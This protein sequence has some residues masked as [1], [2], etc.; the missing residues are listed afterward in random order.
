MPLNRQPVNRQ[1]SDFSYQIKRTEFF[2]DTVQFNAIEIDNTTSEEY[3]ILSN[4]NV[5]AVRFENVS[6]PG[7]SFPNVSFETYSEAVQA[8]RARRRSLRKDIVKKT[9]RIDLNSTITDTDTPVAEP[10]VTP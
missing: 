6:T 4:G 1:L 8:V 9:R 10:E 3:Y 2:D 7:A 5:A